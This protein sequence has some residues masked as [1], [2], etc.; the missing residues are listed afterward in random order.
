MKM[1]LPAALGAP[2]STWTP[3]PS[4]MLTS[5]RLR[6]WIGSENWSVTAPELSLMWLLIA[7]VEPTNVAWARAGPAGGARRPPAT[8]AP[9]GPGGTGPPGG[10]PRTRP[11]PGDPPG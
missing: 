1:R 9:T 5:P 4:T 6:I 8:G 7:G 11:G 2:L 10:A 3:R